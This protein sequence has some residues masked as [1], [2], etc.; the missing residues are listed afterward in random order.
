MT[1]H[2]MPFSPPQQH[3]NSFSLAQCLAPN[4]KLTCT[5]PAFATPAWLLDIYEQMLI[6]RQLDEKATTL[7]RTGQL[8]TYPSSRGHEGIAVTLGKTI[9]SQDVFV[10]YYRDQGVLLQ[11]DMRPRDIFQYWG[12]DERANLHGNRRDMPIC[13][14]I[15]TQCTHAAGIAYALQY[16]N[17]GQVVVCSLGDGATSKGDFAEAL[18]FS[19]V[20]NLPILYVITNNQ[21]AISVPL[22]AQTAAKTLAHKAQAAGC[23]A[24]R[25]DGG[26]VIALAHTFQLALDM[27]RAQQGPILIEALTYRL[28][29]HT[30]VDDASRYM[31]AAERKAAMKIES[32]KRLEDYLHQENIINN[33]KVKDLQ[34]TAK[35]YIE[36]EAAAAAQIHEAEPIE[37]FDSL[38]ADLPNEL[39]KQR[40][41]CIYKAQ[42]C[43]KN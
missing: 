37:I 35:Q 17:S 7:Q 43:K 32:M 19:S 1:L 40:T 18:N 39:K 24:F 36:G 11:R 29:D 31:P 13:I 10:P 22:E 5:L 26:D 25:V 27:C 15:A 21:W 4:L 20:K 8:G 3:D 9:L 38:Y 12:G 6:V 34:S 33:D 16:Q 41:H 42:S 28:C 2:C 14:P 23:H 30:T